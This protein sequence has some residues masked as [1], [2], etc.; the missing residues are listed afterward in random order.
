MKLPR[1]VFN[2]VNF[3]LILMMLANERV[4]M[5]D[6][7]KAVD[8]KPDTVK[9]WRVAVNRPRFRSTA[10]KLVLLGVQ[11]LMPEKMFECGVVT[12]EYR[13]M[14]TPEPV[15]NP[16]INGGSSVDKRVYQ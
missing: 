2:D 9:K 4:S 3:S 7:C 1:Y 15:Q 8:A 11:Y 12:D 6:I 14:T 16:R 13:Q 10:D 5:A